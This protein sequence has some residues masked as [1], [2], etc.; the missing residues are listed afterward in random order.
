M[1]VF[2]RNSLATR[3]DRRA[4]GGKADHYFRSHF[5][6]RQER[7]HSLEHALASERAPKR[8]DTAAGAGGS[9]GSDKSNAF[10]R[11]GDVP[12]SGTRARGGLA[13]DDVVELSPATNLFQRG[14]FVDTGRLQKKASGRS[15][16]DASDKSGGGG[17]GVGGKSPQSP[18]PLHRAPP[19]RSRSRSRSDERGT[20]H[21][22]PK[23]SARWNE[24]AHFGVSEPT[25][26]AVSGGAA[27]S[28]EFPEVVPDDGA[29]AG[30]AFAGGFAGDGGVPREPHK[31]ST[32]FTSTP[33]GARGGAPG[34]GLRG[35]DVGVGESPR[36]AARRLA[37]ENAALAEERRRAKQERDLLL[38]EHEHNKAQAALLQASNAQY[39]RRVAQL[40]ALVRENTH[41]RPISFARTNT[42][43][44]RAAE[45]ARGETVA[46]PLGVIET[47]VPDEALVERVERSS[48]EKNV[49]DGRPGEPASFET[50][51]I[52]TRA[53]EDVAE[54]T[55]SG[56]EG[57][58]SG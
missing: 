47:F 24:A 52:E 11:S 12:E 43:G 56:V 57:V 39:E 28:A 22:R 50:E 7:L 49:S 41:S 20:A 5:R 30:G 13:H 26:M 40:E 42:L 55:S 37:R 15:S 27:P 29:F 25:P 45:E 48:F 19:D 1:V 21:T 58:M 32:S 17:S 2:E 4:D 38:A 53:A 18:S 31:V 23:V 9:G 33:G 46:R 8:S 51:K 6:P 44:T 54:K 36:S 16:G 35:A 10:V 14:L 34:S 3:A